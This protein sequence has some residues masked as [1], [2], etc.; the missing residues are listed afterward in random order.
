MLRSLL[1]AAAAIALGYTGLSAEMVSAQ[2]PS[3][4]QHSFGGA[5]DWAKYFDDP[6]RDEWQKPH[7]VM[8]ALALAPNAI[9]ADI[10]SGTGYFSVRFAH[11][12]NKGRVYGVDTEPDM[13]KYLADRA[14]R[15]GLTNVVAVAGRPDNPRL[16][17]KVDLIL[18]VEVFHHI[19]SR[20]VY[21]RKLRDSLKLNGRI[22]IIDFNEKSP[23]GPPAAE[24][25]APSRVKTELSQAGYTLITEHTFLPDQYFLV[26]KPT[27][28]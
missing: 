14:K 20:E 1:F 25:I 6:K 13:V 23:I 15:E 19:G 3:T 24:R 5:E 26:F 27:T 12:V 2:T 22:A 17:V 10:G 9:V 4:H 28:R 18:M 7:E 8:Q 21:F 11:F 16:P